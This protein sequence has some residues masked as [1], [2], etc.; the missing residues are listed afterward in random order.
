ME[1]EYYPHIVEQY[2]QK[3]WEKHNTFH[4]NI[5]YNKKKF[6]CLSMLPYPSGNLHMGHVRNYTISDVIAR[7]HRMLGENVLHP[8]G[9]DAFG[10]PAEIA[11]INHKISPDI[12]TKQNIKYMKQQLKFLGFSFDWNREIT[13]CNDQYYRW[14]QLLFLKLYKLGLVYKKNTIVNWCPNDKTVLANEQVYKNTCWRCGNT[15]ESKQMLQ[16]FL[17]I[18][19]YAEELLYGLSKLNGWPKQ[20]KRMQQNWIGKKEGI[21]IN[22]KVYKT[23]TILKIFIQ[24]KQYMHNISFIK[25]SLRHDFCKKISVHNVTV[26]KFLDMYIY[27]TSLKDN[28]LSFIHSNLFVIDH[29]NNKIPIIIVNIMPHNIMASIGTPL[30]NSEDYVIA[31]KY[32]LI[33][34]TENNINHLLHSSDIKSNLKPLFCQQKTFYSLND[35]CISR[36]R[37]WGTPIPVITLTN[38]EIIPLKEQDLP[39]KFPKY[40]FDQYKKFDYNQKKIINLTWFNYNYNG[41][42]AKREID[43]FDTFIESSWY[44]ARYTCPNYNKGILNADDIKYWLP[45]NQ[46]I[47]GIEHAT[48]HLIYLRFFH[49]LMRDLGLVYNDEPVKNLLCQ[50]MV[51]SDAFYYIDSN[52]NKK[53]VSYKNVHVKYDDNNLNKIFI[54][55]KNRIL[56]RHKMIKMSKS[57]KN[58]IDPNSII[59]KYGADTLRLF[60]MFAAPPTISLEWRASGINGMLKFLKKLWCFIYQYRLLPYN[61]SISVNIT[62]LSNNYNQKQFELHNIINKTIQQ[63]SNDIHERQIFNTAISSIMSLVNYIMKYNINNLI[64]YNIVYYALNIILKL[65]YPFAPHFSYVLLEYFG[66]KN[67]DFL[68]W[69]K[70]F[71]IHNNQFTVS[72]NLVIQINGKKKYVTT[73]PIVDANNKKKIKQIVY[74]NN[75]ISKHLEKIKIIKTIYIYKKIF[76]IVTLK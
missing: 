70:L 9:W 25:L 64:D 46:Y 65:L 35:W 53:W 16:W 17:K 13:T 48:M 2:V 69:P 68:Q 52:H 4:V 60:L 42:Y 26:K 43:T 10:L 33:T 31:H 75:K 56:T 55:N 59:K 38:G 36:Q 50:G 1:K 18:T 54:D 74:K 66:N 37:L 30:Y 22:Y 72:F 44:Y 21:E 57:K 58:G 71:P 23:N 49:K 63:V 51:L 27:Q 76:N 19:N 28:T 40:L 14:E 61:I 6:Y 41:Q 20:V 39:I 62:Q 47:G 3:Q 45:V 8:I 7:Y 5:D 12:W 32:N 73:I 34:Y 15:I 67:I 24:K 11:A 29:L